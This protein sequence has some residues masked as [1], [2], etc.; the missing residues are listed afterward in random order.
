MRLAASASPQHARGGVV[1]AAHVDAD[2]RIAR[3]AR[4]VARLRRV[5]H[6]PGRAVGD[7]SAVDADFWLA[8]PAGKL[9]VCPANV[10][11]RR[12][13]SGFALERAHFPC[14]A[15]AYGD[16]DGL[17]V[18][19][20]VRDAHAA[21]ERP[22]GAAGV[23]PERRVTGLAREGASV[24]CHS[25][26]HSP[27][28]R[29]CQPFGA[30]VRLAR[31]PA[32]GAIRAADVLTRGGIARLAREGARV[33][34]GAAACEGTVGQRCPG[35]ASVRCA[36]ST[37]EGAIRVA[38]VNAVNVVAIIARV[39]AI[40]AR[41]TRANRWRAGQ[42]EAVRA[43][44]GKAGTAIEMARRVAEMS[45]LG[46]VAG[47]TREVA[48]VVGKVSCRAANVRLGSR[49]RTGN[50]Q[51]HLAS[52]RR[53]PPPARPLKDPVAPVLGDV[54]ANQ[55]EERPKRSHGKRGQLTAARRSIYAS[56]PIL[57]VGDR[58][59]VQTRKAVTIP[60]PEVSVPAA[61]VRA[62]PAKPLL[63]R[64]CAH[65]A[66]GAAADRVRIRYRKAPRASNRGA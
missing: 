62:G 35:A 26:A 5:T 57:R 7:P 15:G 34:G 37:L 3:V 29:D 4:E 19:A 11:V 23:R 46:V 14:C 61:Y 38:R 49:K 30:G 64:V 9:P 31:A 17:S 20:L 42:A 13:V 36:A 54:Q 44:I 51:H 43:L 55:R 27:R 63:A 66:S 53:L 22:V 12:S 1:K 33:T 28:V 58:G 10:L 41:G 24:R 60:A 21:K 45:P 25:G 2:G 59:V 39:R 8:G 18:N 56:R 48:H 32:K 65:V 16:S 50:V 6:T 40:G 52:A 47:A